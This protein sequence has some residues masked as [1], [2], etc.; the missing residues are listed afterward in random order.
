MRYTVILPVLN[1]IEGL[2]ILLPRLSQLSC[3]VIVCDNGS[4]D[5]S[6]AYIKSFNHSISLSEGKGS[7]TDAIKRGISLA[8]TD[9]IIVM[10]SDGSHPIDYVGGIANLLE[11]HNMVIGSRYVDHGDNHDS[12]SNVL[13][14]RGFNL[15][16]YGLAPSVKDRAS[17]FWGVRKSLLTN[18]IRDTKKPMLESLVRNR[19]KSVIELPY[20]FIPRKAGKSKLGRSFKTILSELWGL[21]LLYICKFQRPLKFLI[22]GGV[23]VGLNMGLLFLLTEKFNVWYMASSAIGILVATAWNYLINNYWTFGRKDLL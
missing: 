2:K 15:L 16:A 22:V 11:H 23:G 6:L 19:I 5:G 13:I 9:N 8:T 7:V 17:G 18:Q 21:I 10:D 1:E 12:E 3:N 20:T 14:S 4:S